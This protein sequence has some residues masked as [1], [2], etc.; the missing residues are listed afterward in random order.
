[1]GGM[2]KGEVWINGENVGRYWSVYIVKGFCGDCSY[3][4][5]YF[6][7]KCL[8]YCGDVF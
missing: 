5:Y 4:G 1:M 6:E 8:S 2:G 3:V 7:K